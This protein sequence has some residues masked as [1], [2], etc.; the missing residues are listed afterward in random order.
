MCPTP[1]LDSMVTGS[2]KWDWP[3]TAISCFPEPVPASTTLGRH[4]VLVHQ[5]PVSAYQVSLFSSSFLRSSTGGKWYIKY[6]RMIRIFLHSRDDVITGIR[7]I[8]G[9]SGHGQWTSNHASTIDKLSYSVDGWMKVGC[10][11]DFLEEF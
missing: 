8:S 7:Y 11:G 6:G 10:E 5:V 3:P 1:G 2:R 4:K 9:S